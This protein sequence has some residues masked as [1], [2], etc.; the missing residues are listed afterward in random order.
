MPKKKINEN[1]PRRYVYWIIVDFT[2]ISR[3]FQKFRTRY[4]SNDAHIIFYWITGNCGNQWLHILQRFIIWNPF[5]DISVTLPLSLPVYHGVIPNCVFPDFITVFTMSFSIF[6]SISLSLYDLCQIIHTSRK[7]LSCTRVMPRAN[8]ESMKCSF[9]SHSNFLPYTPINCIRDMFVALSYLHISAVCIIFYMA[10]HFRYK[11]DIT[12][13]T[14]TKA[15]ETKTDVKSYNW[16][17]LWGLTTTEQWT[18]KYSWFPEP[19]TLSISLSF[20][21]HC[22]QFTLCAWFLI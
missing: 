11:N 10:W 3:C 20:P 22:M 9:L 5:F 2:T 4:Y 13:E 18:R 19:A 8:F 7:K 1:Q 12:R 21:F 14:E 15:T 16:H 17:K 6:L